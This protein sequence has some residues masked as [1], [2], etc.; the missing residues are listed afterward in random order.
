MQS[1]LKFSAFFLFPWSCLNFMSNPM[2]YCHQ[3][4]KVCILSLINLFTVRGNLNAARYQAEIIQPVV[5]PF[6]R[7]Q[8]QQDPLAAQYQIFQQDGAPAHTARTT[9]AL[10]Q[11]LGIDLMEWPSKSPDLSPIE[12]VWDHLGQAVAERV[13]ENSTLDDLE[14]F[15]KEEWRA[16]DQDYLRDLIWTMRDRCEEC[17]AA[18]GGSTHY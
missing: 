13:T 12:N 9:K 1:N 16:M 7:Q 15:L 17:I 8:R 10:L 5:D 3:S 2:Q 18:Q 6:L 11:Q 14:R 4:C